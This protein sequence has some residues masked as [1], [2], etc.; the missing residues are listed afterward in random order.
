METNKKP[1]TFVKAVFRRRDN[2]ASLAMAG[3]TAASSTGRSD[4]GDRART[5]ERYFQ[6]FTLLKQAIQGHQGSWGS[7]EFEE[8][9]GEPSRFDDPL[10][11]TKINAALES[12][13]KAIENKSLCTKSSEIIESIYT[14]LSPLAKNLLQIA[15]NAQSVNPLPVLNLS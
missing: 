6:A 14:A 11:K 2:Q 5:E 15:I 4:Y 7:F 10:F 12:R 8:L 1:R 3:T 9:S 13:Q